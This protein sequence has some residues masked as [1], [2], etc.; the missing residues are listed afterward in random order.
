M[1]HKYVLYVDEI[2]HRSNYIRQ[3]IVYE[4]DNWR[5]AV[6]VLN[7]E[8][9]LSEGR[10]VKL[11]LVERVGEGMQIVRVNVS[12]DWRPLCMKGE[13]F[14]ASKYGFSL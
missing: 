2:S 7:R 3:S 12:L 1:K 13:D 5:E 9:L 10:Q 6:N 11:Q 4:C 14:D 8:I